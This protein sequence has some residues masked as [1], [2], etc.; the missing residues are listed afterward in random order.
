[1]SQP[2]LYRKPASPGYL[3]GYNWPAVVLGLLVLVLA[4]FFCTQYIANRFQYQ[5]ALGTPLLRLRAGAIYQPFAWIV[6]GWQHMTD[7]DA[8]IRTPFLLEC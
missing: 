5:R 4:N 6:W 3:G 1:M 7:R 2:Q 8:A